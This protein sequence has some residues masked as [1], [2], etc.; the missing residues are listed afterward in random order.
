[1]F[2]VFTLNDPDFWAIVRLSKCSASIWIRNNQN[3]GDVFVFSRYFIH[4]VSSDVKMMC[5][6][7]KMVSIR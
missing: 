1:M 2:E 4:G 5:C 6:S 7:R 3:K